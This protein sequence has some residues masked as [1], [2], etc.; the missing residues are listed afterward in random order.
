MLLQRL[1]VLF[2]PIER[3]LT[4]ETFDIVGTAGERLEEEP[5][6]CELFNA[7]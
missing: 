7:R 5:G 3:L 6:L 4:E 2:P 1:I